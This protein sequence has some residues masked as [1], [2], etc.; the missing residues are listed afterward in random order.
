MNYL[1]I[2]GDNIFNTLDILIYFGS[3][4]FWFVF[5]KVVVKDTINFEKELEDTNV[6]YITGQQ[7][8]RE[9]DKIQDSLLKDD[10]NE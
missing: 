10:Y 8:I 7:M 1:D 2:T 9:I 4:L 6:Y 3:L 5:Y